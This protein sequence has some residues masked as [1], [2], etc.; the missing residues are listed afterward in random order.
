MKEDRLEGA[1]D[2]IK[3]PEYL[4]KRILTK[5]SEI[6]ENQTAD[7]DKH[8]HIQASGVERINSHPIRRTFTAI[9]ACAVLVSGV[10]LAAHYMPR[11]ADIDKTSETSDDN[12]EQITDTFADLFDNESLTENGIELTIEQRNHIKEIISEYLW[13][14]ID[15]ERFVTET[16]NSQSE[17]QIALIAN[18]GDCIY[19]LVITDNNYSV[20]TCKPLEVT[21]EA[22]VTTAYYS[23]GTTEMYEK[24]AAVLNHEQEDVNAPVPLSDIAER[25]YKEVSYSSSEALPQEKRDELAKLF[26]EGTFKYTPDVSEVYSNPWYIFT[27]SDCEL[28]VVSDYIYLYSSGTAELHENGETYFYKYDFDTISKKIDE[29]LFADRM[30][31]GS[32][33]VCANML[34]ETVSAHQ[35]K[36]FENVTLSSETKIAIYDYLSKT[37][38]RKCSDDDIHTYHLTP[39]SK[40]YD[41][42]LGFDSFELNNYDQMNGWALHFQDNGILEMADVTDGIAEFSYYLYDPVEFYSVA[43][44]AIPELSS[45]YPPFGLIYKIGNISVNGNEIPEEIHKSLSNLFFGLNWQNETISDDFRDETPSFTIEAGNDLIIRTFD[46][47]TLEYKDA[48]GKVHTY[49]GIGLPDSM[50]ESIFN[51]LAFWSDPEYY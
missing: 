47:G 27:D 19:T 33:L 43:T 30:F 3:M 50:A 41:R 12:T 26:S 11:S 2:D 4:K 24:I 35:T 16:E 23:V 22:Q 8:Y 15:E 1:A 37:V 25:N 13:T 7:S 51:M 5:C 38:F 45:G 32:D 20:F 14:E 46:D 10:S 31:K 28:E 34:A 6:S 17:G 42:A 29:I 48:D 39:A 9:A 18:S 36:A 49:L 44:D 40:Y 21:E